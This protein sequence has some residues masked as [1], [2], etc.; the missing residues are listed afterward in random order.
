M[1]LLVGK[2]DIEGF[3]LVAG[4]TS[5]LTTDSRLVGD[6]FDW[7]ILDEANKVRVPEALPLM[8][9]AKR[10]VLIGDPLQLGPVNDDASASFEAEDKVG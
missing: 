1:D 2:A 6:E 7:L 5:R 8:A 10:W 3:N 9:H 4:T